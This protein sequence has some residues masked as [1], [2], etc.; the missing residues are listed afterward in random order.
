MDSKFLVPIATML[1]GLAVFVTFA[2][3]YAARG[4][5]K[6]L[7]PRVLAGVCLVAGGLVVASG[8]A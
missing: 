6:Q 2:I 5:L 8:F 1:G 7:S 4:R 3:W